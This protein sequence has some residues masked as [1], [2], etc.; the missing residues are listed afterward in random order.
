MNGKE[1]RE[2]IIK[3]LQNSDTQLAA[4]KIASLLGV[5]R[6]VIVQDIALLRAS[7]YD[8]HAGARGY[9]LAQKNTL[10][11]TFK[12]YH[13]PEDTEE[14]LNLFVDFGGR[15][16]NVFIYHKVYGKIEAPL[17]ITC[18]MDVQKYLE[19]IEGGASALL[20]D[21]TSGYHYHTVEAES[22]EVFD[23]IEMELRKRGFLAKLQDYEPDEIKET[24]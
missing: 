5:S 6:Q 11:K 17:K 2:E 15:V 7:G 13:T 4:G 9:V 1:R 21:A 10:T 24:P 16:Q 22:K 18:R 23:R 14:E 3:L 12:V 8:I 20:S 19:T